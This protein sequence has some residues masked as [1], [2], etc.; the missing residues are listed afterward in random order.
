MNDFTQCSSDVVIQKETPSDNEE[1]SCLNC[2]GTQTRTEDPL[3]PKQ[4]NYL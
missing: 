1:V 3:L 2:R 4:I